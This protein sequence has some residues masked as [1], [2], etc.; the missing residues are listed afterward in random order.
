MAKI[1]LSDAGGLGLI[2]GQGT[3]PA[4]HNQ[5]PHMPQ[6]R[7][8]MLQLRST[9][10]RLILESNDFPE[11]KAMSHQIQKAFRMHKSWIYTKVF[12]REFL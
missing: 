8:H 1:P 11:V 3:S 7:S 12:H 2:P 5:R 6:L 9:A 4:C 10:A